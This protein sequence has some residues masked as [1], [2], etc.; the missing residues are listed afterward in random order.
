MIE[1][2]LVDSL[3][4]QILSKQF[5]EFHRMGSLHETKSLFQG[6]VPEGYSLKI[7]ESI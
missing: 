4:G 5:L 1:P 3:G 6:F 7:I 2:E